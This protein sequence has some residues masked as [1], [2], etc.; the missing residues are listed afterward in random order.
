MLVIAH[1]RGCYEKVLLY[2]RKY[3]IKIIFTFKHLFIMQDNNQ[4]S[5][6]KLKES[7]NFQ[8]QRFGFVP[9]RIFILI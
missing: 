7:A 6:V 9:Y 4:Y 3:N 5:L 8:L 1:A 2:F